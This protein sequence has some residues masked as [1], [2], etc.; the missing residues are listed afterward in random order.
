M[1]RRCKCCRRAFQISPSKVKIGRGTTC[2]Q[3]CRYVLENA[4]P[5]RKRFLALIKKTKGGC[6]LWQGK[7]NEGGYGRLKVKGKQRFAHHLGWELFKGKI[8]SGK[9]VL[10]DCPLGDNPLCVNPAHLWLGTTRQNNEDM[11]LKGRAAKGEANGSSTLTEKQVRRIKQRLR[12]ELIT[13][14]QLAR[15]EKV[16]KHAVRRVALGLTWKHVILEEGVMQCR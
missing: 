9:K 12:D 15:E 3:K 5:L 1:I 13:W 11:R 8:P 4:V 16:T 6:W 7:P 14:A 2:S 10:H